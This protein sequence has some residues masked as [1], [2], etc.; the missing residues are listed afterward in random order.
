M[1]E[2]DEY[3]FKVDDQWY[4]RGN[5]SP[6]WLFVANRPDGSCQDGICEKVPSAM[7]PLLNEIGR[8]IQV[9]GERDRIRQETIEEAAKVCTDHI[10]W[11]R[12]Y[13]AEKMRTVATLLDAIR[14]LGEKL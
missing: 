1:S 12:Q 4:Y 11:L 14:A 5:R 2:A 13:D 10:A 3:K 9:Q 8:L 7:W 6:T